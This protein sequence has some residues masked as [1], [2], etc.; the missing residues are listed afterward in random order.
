MAYGRPNVRAGDETDEAL[1]ER[2]ARGDAS[3]LRALFERYAP[4]LHA[5]FARSVGASSEDLLQTTFLKLHAARHDYVSGLPLRPWIFTIAARARADE[6]RRRYRSRLEPGAEPDETADVRTASPEDRLEAQRV[7]SAI[8][9]LPEGQRLVV[10]LHRF[11]G[12]TFAE[13][14]SVIGEVEKKSITEGA[15]R[16]RAFRAYAALREKLGAPEREGLEG[17]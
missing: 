2:Y 4:R 16:I 10:Y 1:M 9:E 11:E 14:A 12:L 15:A 13:I 7:H 3:A 5:F 17:P 6:L 8:E